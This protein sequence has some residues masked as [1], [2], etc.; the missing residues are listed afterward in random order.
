MRLTPPNLPKSASVLSTASATVKSLK[1][2]GATRRATARQGLLTHRVFVLFV[3]AH[4]IVI[5]SAGFTTSTR[6]KSG[7]ND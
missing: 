4:R 6:S 7:G 5:A 3:S 1:A 2:Y